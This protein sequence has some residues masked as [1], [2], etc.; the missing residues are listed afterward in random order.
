M[1]TQPLEWT[2]PST[3]KTYYLQSLEPNQI[4]QFL[5]SRQP[6][7]PEDAKVQGSDYEN[8]CTT[9]LTNTLNP[10]QPKEELEAAQRILSNPMDLT[11]VSLMLSQGKTP[12]LF[13]LQ[14]QQ[15]NQMAEEFLQEW[16]YE[17][18][19][20]K[21]SQAIYQMRLNDEKAL[22]AEDFYQE[23]LSLEDEK[24][25]MAVSRQ[26]TDSKGKGK[27]EWYFRHDKIMDFF[28]VQNFLGDSEETET[29]LID[30]MNDPRFRGVYFLL[31][32]L[33][34]LAEAKQLRE[35]LIQYAADTKDHTVSDTFVQILRSRA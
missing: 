11:L 1:T 26:W 21:F 20:K 35:Q 25:K 2:P 12:D 29:R 5:V 13:H 9:Y 14:E 31:A 4:Q 28:L 17:F 24:Y 27:K 6:R 7:L 30:H 32:T 19:L 33:L 3:A 18:P 8:A 22:P 23:L 10:Q 34:P 15:Y 16:R